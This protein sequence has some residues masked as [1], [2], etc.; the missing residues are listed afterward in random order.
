MIAFT[1]DKDK[2]RLFIKFIG[3]LNVDE[4][5]N[6]TK[7]LVEHIQHLQSG[8]DIV[9]DISKF[10]DSSEEFYAKFAEIMRFLKNNG[11]GRIIR[12]VGNNKNSLMLFSRFD[13]KNR[14]DW[15]EYAPNI[16]SAVLRLDEPGS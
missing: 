15:V 6:A 16:H 8:F 13:K 5:E 7:Q 14:F 12:V 10:E 9:N 1:I 3:K 11:V 2:N 4:L